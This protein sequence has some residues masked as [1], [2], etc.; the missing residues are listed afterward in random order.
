MT[1][2]QTLKARVRE[3]S[4]R[5]WDRPGIETRLKTLCEKG[6]PRKDLDPDAI[7]AGK[8]EILDRVQRRG[9]VS[10]WPKQSYSIWRLVLR[11]LLSAYPEE[12]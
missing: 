2:L 12:K 1:D 9:E 11:A 5:Q 10:N 8:K 3:L 6:I 4:G 7:T